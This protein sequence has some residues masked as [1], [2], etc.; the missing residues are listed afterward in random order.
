MVGTLSHLGSRVGGARVIQ[1]TLFY[2]DPNIAY[3]VLRTTVIAD[4]VRS[5]EYNILP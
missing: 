5:T 1:P 4:A 2:G 3:E